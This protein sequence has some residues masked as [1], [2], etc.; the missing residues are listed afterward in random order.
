VTGRRACYLPTLDVGAS[1][2]P[3]V[4][5]TELAGLLLATGHSCW[6][7]SNAPATG[8]AIS[9]LIIDGKVSCMDV[10]SLDP[11]RIR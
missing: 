5:H 6:G 7:I 3:L 10:A 2:D 9:E 4:G 8:K 11:R 1:S